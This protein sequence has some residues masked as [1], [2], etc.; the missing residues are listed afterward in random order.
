MGQI[1]SSPP[2]RNSMTW[3][4]QNNLPRLQ[5][6]DKCGDNIRL[7]RDRTLAKRFES[8]CKGVT[9][10][11]RPILTNERVY[12]RFSEMSEN[13]SGVIRFGFTNNDPN[14]LGTLP[15]YACPD[16][17]N[18]PGYW[19]KALN[20]RYCERDNILFYYVTA[21][22]DVYFGVNGEE[23]GVFI[24]GV[25]TG[26]PMWTIIDIYGNCTA[27]EFLDP[28]SC[29]H[30]PPSRRQSVP[31]QE[32]E[33]ILPN[34]Q[35][36]AITEH[37]APVMH[38]SNSAYGNAY[39]PVPFHRTKGQ[40]V[41]LSVDKL[42]ATRADTEYHQGYVF[43]ARPICIGEKIIVQI[44]RTDEMYV[45]TLALGLTSC[46]PAGLSPI[47]LPSDS[48]ELLDR[49][50]YWVVT[51]DVGS[52]LRRGDEIIFCV[53]PNGELQISK[54]NGPPNVVVHVDQSLRLWAFL[55][56][57]GSTTSVRVFSHMVASPP[58]YN[59]LA[60]PNTSSIVSQNRLPPSPMVRM[61]MH[62]PSSDSQSSSS[63]QSLYRPDSQ[64]RLPQSNHVP[65]PTN[66][67]SSSS[68][69]LH[70]GTSTSDM[71]QLQP[72]G[73]VL[74]VNLP[75]ATN[76]DVNVKPPAPRITQV[77]LSVAQPSTSNP[78]T[79]K[80]T[81]HTQQFGAHTEWQDNVS[82]N[83]TTGAE[84]TICCEKSIDSVLYMCGHMC[85][86][87]DCAITQW[88][89]IGGGHCPLCR[90]VIRDVIRTYKS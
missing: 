61:S 22:G 11:A 39:I 78:M 12:V 80:P 75:P 64:Q 38:R 32:V 67:P 72:G 59:S 66:P 70:N 9:F 46:D 7:S 23:K 63:S 33:R 47:D 85:M 41:T 18:K 56:V 44:L 58:P 86:C 65:P 50:E 25:D 17:T 34:M 29:L 37:P 55:D 74:V 8:F 5:F 62:M 15:K 49:P 42:V 24:T 52:N 89:G 16:L 31:T 14:S 26:K 82:P 45:G 69:Y 54:N 48:D 79:Q 53:T 2:P 4:G 35:S 60:L 43:T 77:P 27:I 71:I 40:N 36:L 84:C 73:T 6:H 10:S 30:Q 68:A 81:S 21:A 57:Y 51:K 90:A 3:A 83:H 87:Y 19:A 28:R 20:E 1:T 76:N 13:W 88:R